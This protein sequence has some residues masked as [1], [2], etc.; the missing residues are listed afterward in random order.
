MMDDYYPHIIST[1]TMEYQVKKTTPITNNFMKIG[2]T[3]PNSKF[4]PMYLFNP[5]NS[6]LIRSSS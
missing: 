6:Y 4:P 2:F 3:I 5:P 1:S